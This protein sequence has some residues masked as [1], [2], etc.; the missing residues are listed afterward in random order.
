MNK[1]YYFMLLLL[2]GTGILNV[3]CS[4]NSQK[5]TI[6]LQPPADSLSITN[7]TENNKTITLKK[8][9]ENLNPNL[10]AKELKNDDVAIAEIKNLYLQ[11]Q[12]KLTNN[13]LRKE[14]KGYDCDGDPG[15]GNLLRYFEGNDLLLMVHEFSTEHYWFS[16]HIFL[17]NG[18]PYFIYEEEGSWG[19]GGP[20][21]ETQS[22]TIDK[23]TE[24][25]YYLQN[26]QVIQHLKKSFEEKSWEAKPNRDKIP[27]KKMKVK[28]GE[29]YPQKAAIPLWMEGKVSCK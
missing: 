16:K 9:A 10:D 2:F 25:R 1:S 6:L 7:Q 19:F 17:T 28:K 22:N 12:N 18:E 3:G 21:S 4:G 14:T 5:E 13:K 8:Q 20:Q 23:I 24:Q 27:N 15:S 11:T 29:Q 26:G